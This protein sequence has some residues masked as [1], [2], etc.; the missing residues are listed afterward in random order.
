ELEGTALVSGSV[1]AIGFFGTLTVPGVD[2]AMILMPVLAVALLLPYARG[3]NRLPIIGLALASSG[4][5]LFGES[6][7]HP[8][9]IAQPL[10]GLFDQAILIGVV[11]LVGLVMAALADYSDSASRSLRA[12]DASVIEHELMS[13]DRVALS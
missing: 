9:A 3:H 12:L 5:I 13:G 2:Q 7:A 1:V 10:G 11:A 8:P 4:V 6:I